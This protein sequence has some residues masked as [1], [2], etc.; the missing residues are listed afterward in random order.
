LIYANTVLS[1]ESYFGE[2][3]AIIDRCIFES[4]VKII[5]LCN[6]SREDRFKRYILDGLKVELVFKN[7]INDIIS[8]RQSKPLII[9]NRMLRSIENYIVI[10]GV[11]ENEIIKSK[12]LPSLAS[13]IE[14]IG[15]DKLLY[16]VGQKIGS[17]HVHG[18]WPSLILHYLDRENE[19]FTVRHSKCETNANQY[20]FIPI[21]VLCSLRKFIKHVILKD[22]ISKIFIDLFDSIEEEIRKLNIEMIGEDFKEIDVS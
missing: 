10:S 7:K 3:T 8:E 13:M 19:Q 16:V 21:F 15:Q 5:W 12:S 11:Q 18:T 4:T 9:E 20:V 2:T 1:K 17:H 6:N 14:D 22:D